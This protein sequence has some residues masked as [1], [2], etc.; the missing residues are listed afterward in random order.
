MCRL[1]AWLGPPT[2]LDQI[3]LTPPHSLREQ[4]R[5]PRELPPGMLNA[6]GHGFAWY[7]P[8]RPDAAVYRA[9]L[10]LWADENLGSITPHLRS[11]CVVATTRSATDRMPVSLTN[12]APFA[13]GRHALVHN[14]EVKDFHAKVMSP[15]RASLPDEVAAHIRGNTDSE[16]VFALLL[17]ELDAHPLTD[18]LVRAVARCDALVRQGATRA[19]LNLIASDG[20]SVVA[21]RHA[22]GDDPPSLYL[23]DRGD[24]GAWV[25]SEPVDDDPRW[26]SVPPE[27]VVVLARG[28][29]AAV[30]ALPR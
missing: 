9:V 20:A 8:E 21:V 13:R 5:H 1:S 6:D 27:S 3:L 16:H 30:E 23:C 12:T 14:G 18:A 7:T 19:Q 10:P 28:R 17:A 2:T 22:L 26:A 15:L 24:A 11:G 29:A 25:A 4:S